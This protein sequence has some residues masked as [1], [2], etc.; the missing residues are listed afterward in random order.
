MRYRNIIDLF[1]SQKLFPPNGRTKKN[2]FKRYY[3]VY[4][5]EES[6]DEGGNPL[7]FVSPSSPSL[8][9]PNEKEK[10]FFENNEINILKKTFF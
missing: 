1:L 2:K 10:Y 7:F 9:P 4:V 8:P 6:E 3:N 5:I